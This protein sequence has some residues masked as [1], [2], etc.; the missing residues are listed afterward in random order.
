MKAKDLAQGRWPAVLQALKI[1]ADVLDGKHHPCPKDGSGLDRFRF[2]DRNGSGNYFCG[3][4]DG[5]KGGLGL[6]MCCRGWEYAE[7]AR[8]VERVVGTAVASPEKAKAD[9]RVALERIRK[10]SKRTGEPVRRYLAGRGLI[11]PPGLSAARLVY[12][13]GKSNVGTFDT[14]LGKIVDATG[15]PLSWHITYLQNGLKASVRAPR[16]VMTPVTTINGGA[17][18]LF[19]LAEHLGIGEGIETSIAAHMLHNELPVWPVINKN[20]IRTFE[21]PPSVKRLT[22]FAD[23]D[24]SFVGQAAAY[25][26]A[27]RLT[28]RGVE[29][30]VRVPELPDTDWNDELLRNAAA[31]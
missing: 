1:P 5:T 9:P 30:D 22:I 24:A 16:K 19:P 12:W 8:E 29:C 18:R 15:K 6:L 2:N 21:P 26:C 17:I 10:L 14:M 27:E 4:S 31:A 3:C 23:N 11:V 28:K 25:A 7:A 20:G 13:D